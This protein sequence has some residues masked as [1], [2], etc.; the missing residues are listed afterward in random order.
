MNDE[1]TSDLA[2]LEWVIDAPA[3]TEVGITARHQRAGTVRRTVK[4]A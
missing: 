3:G 1:S 4:L 2:K